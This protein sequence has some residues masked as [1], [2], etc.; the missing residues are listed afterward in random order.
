MSL[1][2]TD[3]KREQA[4][5]IALLLARIDGGQGEDR[6]L[7]ADIVDTVD[8]PRSLGNPVGQVDAALA[9]ATWL[10]QDPIAV[11][12]SVLR[13]KSAECSHNRLARKLCATILRVHLANLER[14]PA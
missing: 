11:V 14:A 6:I 3:A 1:F 8:A 13:E 5:A 4:A 7:G 10:K 12:T 2:T 9:L